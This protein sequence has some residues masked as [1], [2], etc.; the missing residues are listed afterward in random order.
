M[1]ENAPTRLA[2][3]T[4]EDMFEKLKWDEQQ[5]V[6]SWGVYPTFNFIVTAHHLYFD[7]IIKGRGAKPEQTERARR[8]PP[9]GKLLFQ[10]ITEVSNGT[11]HWK[12]TRKDVLEHQ[13]VTDV[14]KPE[15]SDYDSYFFG[16]MI[17]LSY[18]G[19]RLSMS[20]ASALIMRYFEW[21]IY[22]GDE[23]ALDDLS[24]AMLGMQADLP[25]S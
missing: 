24:V 25:A 5:L 3:D 22:G 7:W 17:Y 6:E 14:S 19:Y 2:L 20:A 21:I 11:K 15:V 23:A 8:L 16:E 12:L 4:A 1:S 18:N 13:V 10:A 9:N